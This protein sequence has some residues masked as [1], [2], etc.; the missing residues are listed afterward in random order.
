MGYNMTSIKKYFTD[1]YQ[2]IHPNYQKLIVPVV[3]A[4]VDFQGMKQPLCW[5]DLLELV[6]ERNEIT[7]ICEA[8][9]PFTH[10]WEDLVLSY[11]KKEK[12]SAHI[13]EESL[14]CSIQ[15]ILKARSFEAKKDSFGINVY[16]FFLESSITDIVTLNFNTHLICQKKSEFILKPTKKDK[17][18]RKISSERSF[19]HFQHKNQEKRIWHPHGNIHRL[20]S[21]MLGVRR[22]GASI[23]SL[24]EAFQSLMD[25]YQKNPDAR[26]LKPESWVDLF[27]LR[28]LIFI[29]CSMDIEEYDLWWALRQ[30]ARFWN[31]K[32]NKPPTIILKKDGEKCFSENISNDIIHINYFG[33]HDLCW[34]NLYSLLEQEQDQHQDLVDCTKEVLISVENEPSLKYHFNIQVYPITQGF[35]YKT[36]N[37][38]AKHIHPD[39]PMYVHWYDALYF[40]NELSK[41]NGLQP[42]YKLP[43]PEKEFFQM[44]F[45]NDV[46]SLD[47]PICK[48]GKEEVVIDALLDKVVCD[49][50]ANG[51]RLPTKKEWEFAALANSKTKYSGGND[52]DLDKISWLPHWCAGENSTYFFCGEIALSYI[53]EHYLVGKKAPNKWG[54]HD[55]SCFV[56]QWCWD[57]PV[58]NHKGYIG[59]YS[60][61][62]DYRLTKGGYFRGEGGDGAPQP[63][64]KDNY[65]MPWS[66]NGFRLVRTIGISDSY[67]A[68]EEE[69]RRLEEEKLEAE[70]QATERLKAEKERNG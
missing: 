28:P 59:A 40:C 66:T 21:I 19:L 15:K 34:S 69:K 22:Y 58:H 55:M 11:G 46:E 64:S 2:R 42:V 52:E 60:T 39:I 16:D 20:N 63:I 36:L 51:Y 12:L 70:R 24:D 33:T 9:H 8:S 56:S 4:G 30:R 35:F 50:N 43:I 25:S 31:N 13:A 38:N 1:E 41:Q 49:F 3:G 23:N 29:G 32:P 65:E 18:Y 27:I 67:S 68:E 44:I 10:F 53:E 48:I 5:S 47:V 7:D 45:L 14:L 17:G 26:L 54:L 62:V 61:R 57:I 37:M 6:R